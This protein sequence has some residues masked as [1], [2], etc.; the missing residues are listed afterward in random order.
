MQYRLSKVTPQ[1][2]IIVWQDSL[3]RIHA[4]FYGDEFLDDHER[5]VVK[6]RIREILFSNHHNNTNY[7]YTCLPYELRREKHCNTSLYMDYVISFHAPP[8][9]FQENGIDLLSDR[10]VCFERN[11][12]EG[13]ELVSDNELS[14]SSEDFE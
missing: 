14:S 10:L 9:N 12:F 1:N 13:I 11:Y 7:S 2:L 6:V 3:F 8:D 5:E 4:V